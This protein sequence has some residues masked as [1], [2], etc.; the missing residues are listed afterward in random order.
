MGDKDD[1]HDEQLEAIEQEMNDFMATTD[2]RKIV[3]IEPLNIVSRFIT[4][5]MVY[6]Q[7]PID[8]RGVN[9]RYPN[10]GNQENK[11]IKA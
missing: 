10:R 9:G 7:G 5:M 11:T 3:S 8:L 6:R 1:F 4:I 2:I